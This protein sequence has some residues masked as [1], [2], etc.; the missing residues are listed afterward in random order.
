MK[1]TLYLLAFALF[2]IVSCK[3]ND[4]AQKDVSEANIETFEKLK[5]EAM[6]V[7]DEIM[8]KMGELMELKGELLVNQS[9]SVTQESYMEEVSIAAEN[10]TIAHDDM[11]SWM[12]DYSEK[13]PYES[14]TPETKTIMEEKLPV[15]EQE[16]TEIKNLRDRTIKA[17]SKAKELLKK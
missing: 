15:L 2:A 10:L 3:D 17:I 13:F 4:A 7:H 1:N 6:A 8:P 11:M 5:E 12:K 16:V 14:T 9:E